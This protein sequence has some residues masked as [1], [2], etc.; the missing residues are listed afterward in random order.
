M[1]GKAKGRVALD[2]NLKPLKSAMK[3]GK[4]T[5]SK[6]SK[7]EKPVESYKTQYRKFASS[8]DVFTVDTVPRPVVRELIAVATRE[9]KAR[10]KL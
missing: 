8:L 1:A 5:D 9:I 7:D 4:Q 3:P 2:Q 6:S 10:G